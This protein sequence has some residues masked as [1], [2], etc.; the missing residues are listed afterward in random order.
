M[1][2]GQGPFLP[3]RAGQFRGKVAGRNLALQNA[4]KFHQGHF[5]VAFPIAGLY[6]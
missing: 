1:R 4:G 6:S 2:K 5:S 3:H